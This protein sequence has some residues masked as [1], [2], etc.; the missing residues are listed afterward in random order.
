MYLIITS[1]IVILLLLCAFF[2]IRRKRSLTKVRKMSCTKKCSLLNELAEPFGFT[3]Q[4]VQDI[5]TTSTDAWQKESGCGDFYDQTALSANMVF[6]REPVYFNYRGRTWLI[7]FW[8]GQY[9]ISTGAEAGICH[10]DTIIP[11]ALRRQTIF[12]AAEP[13]EM[14]PVRLRLIGPECPFFNLSQTHWR[15]GG[16]VMGTCTQP[17][18]LLRE[19][20]LT[21]PEESMCRSFT[22]ALIGLGYKDSEILVYGTTVQFYLTDPKVPGVPWDTWVQS[23][24]LWKSRL[25]CRLYL[26]I[27]RPFYSTADRLLF[28]YYLSPFLFRKTLRIRRIGKRTGRHS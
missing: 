18:D 16:F 3:Y 12:P 25:S 28:L 1:I 8:K 21:C 26:W 27:T 7:E 20:V 19:A 4:F 9:G 5:F 22:R 24:V 6:D 11:P 23:Y 14:L 2:C 15:P 10:A 13:E 17:E